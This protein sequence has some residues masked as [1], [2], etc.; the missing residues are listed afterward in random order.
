V[1]EPASVVA[2]LVASAADRLAAAGS[3]SPRLDAELLLAQAVGTDQTRILAHPAALVG[4]GPRA[5][6][7]ALVAR[8]EQGEPVA[9]LRGF[10]EFHGLA[11]STDER[12]L[13]PRPETELLVDT[14]LGAVSARLTA[15]PRPVGSPPLLVADVGTGSGAI[16]VALLVALRRRR[17]ADQVVVDAVDLSGEALQLARANAA[18][19]GVADRMTFTL[20]DLLRERVEPRYAVI[21]ANL[22]YVAT[23]DLA[24]LARDLA[25]E[26]RVALDGGPDGLHV[27]RRLL[28]LLPGTLAADGVALLEIGADQGEGIVRETSARLRGWRCAVMTDLAG[29]PRLAVIE[30]PMPGEP[31]AAIES[32]TPGDGPA[33]RA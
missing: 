13:I 20:G 23:G 28:D 15:A 1:A 25:F 10:R 21:C 32:P 27:V 16:A 18:S 14:A 29:L 24:G 12:A 8:R 3:S 26:P 5:T 9:Y 22:P 6:F 4:D 2:A 7:E 17:M 30:P 33:A 11:I 19:H 31:P